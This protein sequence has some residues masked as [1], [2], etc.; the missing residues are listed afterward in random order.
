M[1]A[2]RATFPRDPARFLPNGFA[3]NRESN[4]ARGWKS[5]KRKYLI[6]TM[7]LVE[8]GGRG[9]GGFRIAN[10]QFV[11]VIRATPTHHPHGEL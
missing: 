8:G 11:D 4:T 6:A 7:A 3:P 5:A 1:S 9:E 10:A 2:R